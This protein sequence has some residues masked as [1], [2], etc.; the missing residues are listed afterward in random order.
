MIDEDRIQKLEDFVGIRIMKAAV[1]IKNAIKEQER[2][3]RLVY[4]VADVANQCG[5][6]IS[7]IRK[8]VAA[9]RLDG[10]IKCNR[11]LI[12]AESFKAWLAVKSEHKRRGNYL[13]RIP[14]TKRT[15]EEVKDSIDN[16]SDAKN[17]IGCR[18][19]FQ[20]S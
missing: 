8:E 18:E 12:T 3:D 16:D 5:L 11:L 15:A 17:S 7:T 13:E 1:D 20:K 6:A 2:G 9:G 14:R 4:T 19:K 10:V